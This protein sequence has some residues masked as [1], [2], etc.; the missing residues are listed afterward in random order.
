MAYVT[1]AEY[2]KYVTQLSGGEDVTYSADAD[3]VTDDVLDQATAYIESQTGRRYSALTDTR[4]YDA[5]A[6]V[7]YDGQLLLLDDDLLTVTTLTNGDGAVI[8]ASDYWLEPRN[9][10][11]YYGIRLK[12]TKSWSFSTDG[13]VS[14]A[15]TWGRMSTPSDDVKRV[16][17]RLAHLFMNQRTAT[18]QVTV[19][20]DGTRTYE[21]PITD[22]LKHWLRREQRVR[23]DL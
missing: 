19:F 22:D 14:I 6:V 12:S 11:L 4:Y 3:A 17:L 2:R 16:T 7:T 5:R 15:G 13:Q 18:G 9:G 20:Q 1:R 23:G 10:P 21:V 8:S